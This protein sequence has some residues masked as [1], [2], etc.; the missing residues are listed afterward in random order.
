LRIA[1]CGLWAAFLLYDL[2]GNRT[3]ATEG[4]GD[5]VEYRYDDAYQLTQAH[6]KDSGNSTVYNDRYE[7]DSAGNRT[8]LTATG[9]T[10]TEGI[11]SARGGLASGEI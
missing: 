6:K 2:A 7:H 4:D 1:D 3:K 11:C 10:T 9:G 5:T 8:K